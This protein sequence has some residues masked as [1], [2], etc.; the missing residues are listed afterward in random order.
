MSKRCEL[1]ML[2]VSELKPAEYNPRKKLKPGDKEYKKIKN[3]IEEFGFA[4]PLVVN[5]D[6]TIIGG[7]QRLSVA[8]DLGY[9]EVPCAVVDVDKTREKA[10]NIALNKI[11]G[12]WDEQMLIDLITELKDADYD[13]DFTGF[14]AP[15]VEEL[16]SNIHNKEVKED[17]FD[18]DKALEAEPFVKVGD[19]W[20]LGK[21]HLMCGDSTKAEQVA[22]LME[23]NKA[24]M[25]ITDP[26]YNCSYKGG[27]GMTIMNDKWT[28]SEAFYHFLLDAFKN[29]YDNLADGGAF[30]AFHSDAEK[31]NFFNATVAA[32]FHYS[33]TCIWVKNALVIGRMDYQ[34]RHEPVIYAFK[35]TAKHKF[36]GDRKQTTVW[37]YDRPTK[38]KLHPTMKTLQVVGYPIKMS[39]QENGIVVDLFGGS[40]TTLMASEQLNRISYLM[41]LDPKYASAIVRRYTAY[42]QGT[43]DI[44]VIREGKKLRCSDVY[45]PS[46]EDLEFQED[47]VNRQA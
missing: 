3:S 43:K 27:T 31:V 14:D 38:S 30:Y 37:E 33:T 10:L 25:C 20:L 45:V 19:I 17:D 34:M 46:R 26:P 15:E 9:T 47:K 2:P 12:E 22:V 44:F 23:G 42:K 41:E 35:D 36:Y 40:G 11:T 6:M 18:V 4:D 29:A 16:L 5:S 39:S 7:H 32:G 1:K 13:L 28:D 8:M 24:N 21:H